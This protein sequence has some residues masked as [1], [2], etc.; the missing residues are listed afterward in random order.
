MWWKWLDLDK[1]VAIQDDRVKRMDNDIRRLTNSV[2]SL[3]D[4]VEKFG[5]QLDMIGKSQE[6][7]SEKITRV[8]SRLSAR[9]ESTTEFSRAFHVANRIFWGVLAVCLVAAQV[10]DIW[11]RY[12]PGLGPS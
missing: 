7:T 2:D 10:V 11:K 12:Y 3:G 9:V 6:S 1:R 8:D 4:K 5:H